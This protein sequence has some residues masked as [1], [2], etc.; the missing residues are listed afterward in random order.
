MKK[1]KTLV[2]KGKKVT[3]QLWDTAGQDRFK[4]I[5]RNF[6]KSSHGIVLVYDITSKISFEA[7]KSL[8]LEIKEFNNDTKI[9]LLGNNKELEDQRNVSY[10]VGEKFAQKNNLLFIEA[11]PKTGDNVS[12]AF[13]LLAEEIINSTNFEEKSKKERNRRINISSKNSGLHSKKKNS[14]K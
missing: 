7:A 8:L 13:E 10:E 9:L 3:L 4:G 11:S 1:T 12:E 14:C 5:R 2:I 6:I